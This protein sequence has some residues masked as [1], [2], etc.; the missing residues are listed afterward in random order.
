MTDLDI[1]LVKPTAKI[2]GGKKGK[3][4]APK[5]KPKGKASD[6]LSG[7]RNCKVKHIVTA[8]ATCNVTTVTLTYKVK[9]K[10]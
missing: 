7:L 3:T 10:T 2:T 8:T 5:N 4:Y 1:D 6:A 9:R